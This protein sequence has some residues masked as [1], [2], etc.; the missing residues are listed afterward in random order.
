VAETDSLSAADT[1]A[2]DLAEPIEVPDRA[3]RD[4]TLVGRLDPAAIG[5]ERNPWGSASGRFLERAMRHTEGALPSR[6]LHIALRNVLLARAESPY[7]ID[8]ADWTAERAWLL[9]RMGEADAARMLVA[10]VDVADFTPK[11]QQISVQSALASA[12]PAGMCPI[13]D[14]LRQVEPRIAPLVD[15]ILARR[16]SGNGGRRHR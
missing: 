4:P 6:W 3:R 16:Q 14:G 1:A 9:L 15:A 5:L 8:G 13:R 7:G 2:A 10:G 11:L 12:D